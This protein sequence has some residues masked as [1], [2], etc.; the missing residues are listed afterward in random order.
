VIVVGFNE[1]DVKVVNMIREHGP[2]SK[3]DAPQYGMQSTTFQNHAKKLVSMGVLEEIKASP[4]GRGNP[5]LLY[6]LKGD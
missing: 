6:N 4:E 1:N 2:L 5:K 3:S